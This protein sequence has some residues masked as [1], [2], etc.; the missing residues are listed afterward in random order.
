MSDMDV[1][2]SEE[3]ILT[4]RLSGLDFSLS[5]LVH[6]CI[7]KTEKRSLHLGFWQ[8][9]Q[10]TFLMRKWLA[11]ERCPVTATASAKNSLTSPSIHQG[12]G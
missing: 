9:L 12:C 7:K 1:V 3:I 11:S 8:H 10:G 2:L 5:L 6:K 4:I